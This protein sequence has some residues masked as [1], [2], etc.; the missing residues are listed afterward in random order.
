MEMRSAHAFASSDL[1]MLFQSAEYEDGD[2]DNSTFEEGDW[3]GDGDFDS[4]Y[5]VAAFR[6][7]SYEDTAR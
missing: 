1:V 2:N 6:N 3:N 7:G 5:L 4:S